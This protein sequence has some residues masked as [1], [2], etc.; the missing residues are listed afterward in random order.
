MY[1][2]VG[3]YGHMVGQSG[4]GG[5]CDIRAFGLWAKKLE[6]RDRQLRFSGAFRTEQVQDREPSEYVDQVIAE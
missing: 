6:Q 4:L 1:Q 2:R 5:V 3:E